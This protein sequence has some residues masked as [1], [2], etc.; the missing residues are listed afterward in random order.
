MDRGQISRFLYLEHPHLS[1]ITIE[2]GASVAWT[3]PLLK[4]YKV[5][6]GLPE[7]I[8]GP[9][10]FTLGAGVATMFIQLILL[11]VVPVCAE[12]EVYL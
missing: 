9:Q 4:F 10:I 7:L 1:R 12:C 3:Q 8:L 5:L 6:Y 11:P 2:L